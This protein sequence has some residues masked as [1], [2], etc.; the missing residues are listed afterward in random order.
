MPLIAAD[1]LRDFKDTAKYILYPFLQE[2]GTLF[3]GAPPKHLK[4][5][6]A[7]QMAYC[8]ATGRDFM[9]WKATASGVLYIEQEI[10]TT[11]TK[12]RFE[13]M[14]H[15]FGDDHVDMNFFTKDRDRLSLMPATNG[16]EKLH[17]IIKDLRPKVVV[18][19]PFRKTF[20]AD[21]NSST[22]MTKIFESLTGLQEEFGFASILVHHTS[23]PS[24]ERRACS[25]EALRGSSEIFAH[26]DTYGIFCNSRK[27]IE[28]DVHW[29]FR[30][31]GHIDPFKL[32]FNEGE[33]IMERR[34]PPVT[35]KKEENEPISTDLLPAK[36]VA[37]TV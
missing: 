5:M 37:G 16:R 24:E 22:E 19:D 9:G 33:G 10:G 28:V 36:Q 4:T 7:M 34:K 3:L 2:K 17:G 14:R 8:I 11:I 1:K 12:D 35:K 18:F 13:L 23:K 31:H 20:G 32:I 21:E 25:P 15:H 6:T 27:E 29:T 30:N 26:G